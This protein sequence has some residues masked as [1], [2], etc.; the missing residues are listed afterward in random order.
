MKT[1]EPAQ[2]WEGRAGEGTVSP[3][4]ICSK[5][6]GRRLGPGI[7][8]SQQVG[9]AGRGCHLAGLGRQVPWEDNDAF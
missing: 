1:S 3:L 5:R 9:V 7:P 2:V 6:G 8:G 4:T